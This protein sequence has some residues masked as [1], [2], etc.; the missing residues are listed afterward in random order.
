MSD[1]DV[2]LWQNEGSCVQ[3]TSPEEIEH[4]LLAQGTVEAQKDTV[5]VTYIPGCKHCD[6]VEEL[7]RS[8]VFEATC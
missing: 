5:V 2:K 3:H 6:S 8:S 7:V 1:K 4:I